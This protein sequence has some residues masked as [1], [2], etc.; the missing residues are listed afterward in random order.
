[1]TLGWTFSDLAMLVLTGALFVIALLSWLLPRSAKESAESQRARQRSWSPRKLP[2]SIHAFNG[3]PSLEQL[4]D[5]LDLD[6]KA[7]GLAERL[8]ESGLEQYNR[9]VNNRHGDLAKWR[10][11]MAELSTI[12]SPYEVSKAE[13]IGVALATTDNSEARRTAQME[14]N[15]LSPRQQMYAQDERHALE[16][17]NTIT[18][19]KKRGIQ[20]TDYTAVKSYIA[21][22]PVPLDSF[23]SE[24]PIPWQS[25]RSL[26][27]EVHRP[28]PTGKPPKPE[29]VHLVVFT[30]DRSPLEDSRAVRDG[31]WIDSAK[32]DMLVPYQK[33][34]PLYQW[35]DSDGSPVQVGQR[36]VIDR[37]PGPE[38]ETEFWRRGGRLDQIFLRASAGRDP[39]QQRKA[40]QRRQIRRIVLALDGAMVIAFLA[41]LMIHLS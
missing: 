19:D 22:G 23:V 15:A 35:L 32:H 16:A 24:L 40:Y 1:M 6:P 31:D 37:D 9:P 27:T 30:A 10:R 7:V 34:I 20:P 17:E 18:M 13:E 14:Y 25:I 3:I 11:E 26:G 8:Y 2:Y 4:I 29:F 21:T 38:W 28:K 41:Y 33:P 12:L 36:V 39:D 5:D